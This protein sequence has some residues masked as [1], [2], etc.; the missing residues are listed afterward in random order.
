MNCIMLI[1]MAHKKGHIP[2][3]KG[4]SKETSKIVARGALKKSLW[5]S[6]LKENY[7]L[8]YKRLCEQTGGKSLGQP[9]LKLERNPMWKGGKRIDKRD[10]YVLLQIPTHP[11][12]RKDG[13]ILEHRLV[14]ETII[15]RRLNK[16]EDVNHINGKKDDNRPE[17]LRLV[18]HFAH[19]EEHECPKCNFKFYT[20]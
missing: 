8:E 16:D 17:N 14:M 19:Y 1:D 3:N 20:R 5:W 7:P 13:S 6:N 15:G 4:L 2:W 9:G 11:D 12:S 10:G 18:R